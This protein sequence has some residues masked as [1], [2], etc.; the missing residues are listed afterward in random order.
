MLTTSNVIQRGGEYEV[1]FNHMWDS[2]NQ[3]NI[4][5][6][7][8]IYVHTVER[9]VLLAILYLYFDMTI[10]TGVIGLTILL[11]SYPN[12]KWRCTYTCYI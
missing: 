3:S 5:L 9:H 11:L 1:L 8:N 10:I 7:I 2:I 4:E 6:A 12:D